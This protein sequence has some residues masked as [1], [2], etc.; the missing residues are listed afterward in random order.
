MHECA[1]WASLF[2]RVLIRGVPL[3]ICLREGGIFEAQLRNNLRRMYS[4]R[5]C[6][7]SY[8]AMP[9]FIDGNSLWNLL[10]FLETKRNIM[11]S[12]IT[13]GMHGL[14]E[15]WGG[16]GLEAC[17]YYLFTDLGNSLKKQK[18]LYKVLTP[19]IKPPI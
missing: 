10:G 13:P 18:S 3:Y 1:I 12:V 7:L 8:L 6:C 4:T 17:S 5:R 15:D 16:G 19:S 9:L 2:Q 11:S 14:P